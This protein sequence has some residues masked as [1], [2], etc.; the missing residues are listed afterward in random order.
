MDENPKLPEPPKVYLRGDPMY[1][2]NPLI[3]AIKTDW[4]DLGKVSVHLRK[5]PPNAPTEADRE[6]SASK[7]L[8][9][10]GQISRFHVTLERHLELAAI[11]AEMV[12]EGYVDRVPNANYWA[13]H[14]LELEA[15]REAIAS[16]KVRASGDRCLGFIGV[17]GLGKSKTL[18]ALLDMVDQVVVHPRKV[19]PNKP[20][21]QVLWLKVE[22]PH[23]RSTGSIAR[24]LLE[25]LGAAVGANY[26]KLHGSGNAVDVIGNAA[27]LV[28]QHCVGLIVIDEIQN[29]VA[30]VEDPKK[31]LVN[32]FVELSNE[33]KVPILFVGTPRAHEVLTRELRS[34]RRLLGPSWNNFKRGD[35]DWDA[36]V[37]TMW[38]YQWNATYTPLSEAL[39]E[40]LYDLTQGVPALLNRLF[41]FTQRKAILNPLEDDSEPLTPELFRQV[42]AE[43]FTAV[44]EMVDAL[45]S[46][47]SHRIA[48]FEDLPKEFSLE[49]MLANEAEELRDYEARRLQRQIVNAR[50]H[51]G[52]VARRRLA[53][54]A[55][56]ATPGATTGAAPL[57]EIVKLAI[58][59]GRDPIEALKQAGLLG[60]DVLGKRD[61]PS[62]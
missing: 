1:D 46:G 55:T 44:K 61:T 39:K 18:E 49:A 40:T 54:Q 41:H 38:E 11:V 36:L 35:P 23:N 24:K 9:K 56:L 21:Q 52:K 26:F 3:T 12:V 10:C 62:S 30:K 7:R 51:A 15:L 34:G 4:E 20:L 37:E 5:L 60:K 43:N 29:A 6:L 50:R 48:R 31:D 28:R 57:D 47:D 14:K 25:A 17:S 53:L 59:E 27:S 45:R 33:L 13:N 22:C 2:N 58:K 42:F 16:G 19:D 8:R 32:L